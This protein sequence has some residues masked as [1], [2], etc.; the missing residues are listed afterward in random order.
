MKKIMQTIKLR[1]Y[2]AHLLKET[3]EK[4]EG[5]D[6]LI[7]Y[8]DNTAEEVLNKWDLLEKI[9]KDHVKPIKYIFDMT[10]RIILDRNILINID[11]IE[12]E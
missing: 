8:K 1:K 2:K 6:F 5:Q 4:L 10:D 3:I 11:E 9:E 12:K 7:W